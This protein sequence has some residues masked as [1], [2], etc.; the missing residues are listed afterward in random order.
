[1]DEYISKAA[2]IEC[3]FEQSNHCEDENAVL[4][5]GVIAGKLTA[6]SAADVAPVRH[7]KPILKRGLGRCSECDGQMSLVWT[8]CPHCGARMDADAP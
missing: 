5:C 3:A 8:Y 6:M 2:A 4:A 7:G 1:M